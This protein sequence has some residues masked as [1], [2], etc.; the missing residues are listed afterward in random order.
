MRQRQAAERFRQFLGRYPRIFAPASGE[1][2]IGADQAAA[3]CERLQVALAEYHR[4]FDAEPARLLDT[5]K[6]APAEYCD[7]LTVAKTF[8]LAIEEAAKLHSAA[9]PLIVYAS[10]LAP[11]RSRCSC[12]PR[13]TTHSP[14]P[15]PRP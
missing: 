11:N 3:Y 7:R 1:E 8:S 10:L 15:S 13:C 12:S 14:S 4:R 2:V 6:D 9:E 5:E